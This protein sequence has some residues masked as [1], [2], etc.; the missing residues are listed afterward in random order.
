MLRRRCVPKK[1][2]LAQTWH[3]ACICSGLHPSGNAPPVLPHLRGQQPV[4][5][6]VMKRREPTACITWACWKVE[7]S[8]PGATSLQA[9]SRKERLGCAA[10]H[11]LP[12]VGESIVGDTGNLARD[13]KESGE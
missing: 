5:T 2:C 4:S 1:A 12:P 13:A 10:N 3:G 8:A 11:H 7:R 9:G 6:S